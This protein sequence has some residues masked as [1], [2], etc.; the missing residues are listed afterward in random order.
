MILPSTVEVLEIYFLSNIGKKNMLPYNFRFLKI[1]NFL[2]RFKKLKI[3]I[4]VNTPSM[5][6]KTRH[7]AL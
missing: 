2:N 7:S 6:S 5:N 3:L 1:F 4:Q